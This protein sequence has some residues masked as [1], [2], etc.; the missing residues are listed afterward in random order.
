[1]RTL[2][3]IPKMKS[4]KVAEAIALLGDVTTDTKVSAACAILIQLQC[5]ISLSTVLFSQDF[6]PMS[7]GPTLHFISHTTYINVIFLSVFCLL[8]ASHHIPNRKQTN[9]SYI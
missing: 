4:W 1:V 3:Q 9:I 2:Q 5:I 7:E 6:H 8:P